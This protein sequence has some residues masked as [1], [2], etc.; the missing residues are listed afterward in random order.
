[1]SK[2]S[3]IFVAFFF[4]SIVTYSQENFLPDIRKIDKKTNKRIYSFTKSWIFENLIDTLTNKKVVFGKITFR[5]WEGSCEEYFRLYNCSKEIV[6]DQ[7]K[8]KRSIILLNSR[9]YHLD[10]KF[11]QIESKKAIRFYFN[12]FGII[13]SI[14][15]VHNF[16]ENLI[17]SY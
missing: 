4:L 13:H 11:S 15:L 12:Y 5:C 17:I 9:W 10:V 16:S 6:S 8:V 14:W 2:R 7:E 3:A 1:M